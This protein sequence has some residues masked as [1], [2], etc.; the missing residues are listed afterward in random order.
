MLENNQYPPSFFNP[1]VKQ[2]LEKIQI[3]KS[4]VVEEEED[5]PAE[6]KPISNTEAKPRNNERSL[7]RCNIPCKVI[8]TIKS[9]KKW[10][11][12]S[13]YLFTIPI[14]LCWTNYP[15]FANPV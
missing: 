6:E 5:D 8:T 10:F 11:S 4:T 9:S 2:T 15:T 14:V 13:N 1:I 7:K 12:V 3:P